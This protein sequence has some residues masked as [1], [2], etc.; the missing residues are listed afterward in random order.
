MLDVRA[1]AAQFGDVGES[2][3]E[4]GVADG[5]CAIGQRGQGHELRLQIGRHAGIWQR[6]EM[7]RPQAW[8]C[9]ERESN[10]DPVSIV[11]PGSSR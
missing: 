5:A 2:M 11:Q 8:R 9:G 1:Q 10:P 4:N 7:N 6:R 3:R